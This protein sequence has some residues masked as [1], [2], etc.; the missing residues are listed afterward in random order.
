MNILDEVSAAWGWTGIVPDELVTENEF[1]N[2]IIKDPEDKFWRIC[3]EE[4]TCEVVADS[5]DAYNVLI[6]DDEFNED[7]FMAD[8]VAIG[9]KKLGELKEGHKFCLVVPGA[10]GG[11]YDAK[12]IKSVAFDALIKKSGEVGKQ[13]H[14]LPEGAEFKFEK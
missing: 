9:E 13:L 6:Q 2:L 3:P 7:W 14:D 12:N 10:L 11:D 8:M 4:L 5:I 1:G